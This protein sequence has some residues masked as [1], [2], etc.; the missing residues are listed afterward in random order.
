MMSKDTL[1]LTLKLSKYEKLWELAHKRGKEV[2]I[3]T[4]DLKHLLMDQSAALGMLKDNGMG[5]TDPKEK[6][7]TVSIRKD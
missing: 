6:K 7:L 1:E 5:Y 3:N 4:E 2:S